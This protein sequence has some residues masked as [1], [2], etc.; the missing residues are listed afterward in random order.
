VDALDTAQ[1]APLRYRAVPR[2]PRVQR[3]LALLLDCETPA[4]EV[5]RAIREAGGDS[6][7]DVAIFDRYQGR[8][9]PAGKLGLGFRLLFQ[10]ADR[11]L[12]ESEVA[13]ATGR[14][15]RRLQEQFGAELRG[16]ETP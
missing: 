16:G 4:G 14:V 13:A 7:A 12:H 1:P 3:D 10:R 5:A 6:L 11:T 2:H 8:G 9:V 15:L